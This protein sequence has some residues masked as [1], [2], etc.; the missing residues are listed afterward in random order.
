MVA[1]APSFLPSPI[2]SLPIRAQVYPKSVPGVSQ[3][4]RL[5]CTH[6]KGVRLP[7]VRILGLRTELTCEVSFLTLEQ[8]QKKQGLGPSPSPRLSHPAHHPIEQVKEASAAPDK[9]C[10]RE[11]KPEIPAPPAAPLR[12]PSALAF[13]PSS[14][15]CVHGI[16]PLPSLSAPTKV[17]SATGVLFKGTM[18][19]ALTRHY[20]RALTPKAVE[21]VTLQD[22]LELLTLDAIA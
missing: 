10:H 17:E 22:R 6:V 8:V 15:Y 12:W 1:M 18:L 13:G 19:Y 2:G 3:S 11:H 7:I 14:V 4:V 9:G 5:L 21:G 16:S 20:T